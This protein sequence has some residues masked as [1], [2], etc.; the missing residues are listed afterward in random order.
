LLAVPGS[1]Q[2]SHLKVDGI[3]AKFVG[4]QVAELGKGSRHVVQVVDGFGDRVDHFLAMSLEFGVLAHRGPASP[5]PGLVFV[6]EH[7]LGRLVPSTAGLPFYRA[8]EAEPSTPFP[9][10]AQR[11]HTPPHG[12]GEE[13]RWR[14]FS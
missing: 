8:G 9:A 11:H 3:H 4:V 13:R 6:G 10:P 1:H 12:V 7:H 2:P 5:H 14:A